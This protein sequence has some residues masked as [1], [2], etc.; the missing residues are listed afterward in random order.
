MN[1]PSALLPTSPTTTSVCEDATLEFAACYAY[2][3]HGAGAIA[4][5]SRALRVRLKAADPTW[6]PCY[7]KRVRAL[8][9]E[10]GRFT[11]FFGP[12]VLLVPVPGNRSPGRR[13]TW[14]AER[15]AG[16]LVTAGMG[17]AVWPGLVRLRRVRK[18]ATAM[19]G[20]RPTVQEHCASL[21]VALRKPFPAGIDIPIPGIRLL[22]VDDIVTKGRTLFAAAGVLRQRFPTAQIRAFALARTL[23]RVPGLQH[24][25]APC[26]GE[27]RWVAGDTSRE[28]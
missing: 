5:G 22:L 18:S 1:R 16:E 17:C 7:A 24:L 3:P 28:P 12:D 23:G 19:A 11:G 15:L 8:V 21:A 10:S 14:V 20:E 27:I 13:G 4:R 2:S 9:L 25:V 26:E 6:L